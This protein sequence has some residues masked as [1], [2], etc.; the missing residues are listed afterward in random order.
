MV[1]LQEIT[2]RICIC[3]ADTGFV[4][5][6]IIRGDSGLII[7]DTMLFPKDS[8]A[9]A[10]IAKS[11][12]KPIKFVINTHWH[13]DHCYGNR[14]FANEYT[15]VIAHQDF[16]DTIIREKPVIARKESF[17]K[18]KNLVYPHITFLNELSFENPY[19]LK[20]IHMPGHTIDSSIILDEARGVV[21]VG[22]TVLNS[23]DGRFA[24]PYFYWGN[25]NQLLQS[26]KQLLGM[27]IKTII[28]GHGNVVGKDKI[29]LDIRY[30]TTL[31]SLFG[32]WLKRNEVEV[33]RGVELSGE[34]EIA[35][36]IVKDIP[37]TSCLPEF[38]YED[39][40]VPRMHELNI[41]Q[42]LREFSFTKKVTEKTEEK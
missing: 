29:L 6:V 42:L 5:G 36:L 32:K 33:R 13:S 19:K 14:Y 7:I 11:F 10:V 16:R 37:I 18:R 4:N 15:T 17:I 23:R 3:K 31:K 1:T 38:R 40:W 34:I 25:S 20:M 30:I 12:N 9:M 35:S 2:Y 21:I 26:Q 28:P 41:Q 27:D 22:D 24:I 8:R 39:F